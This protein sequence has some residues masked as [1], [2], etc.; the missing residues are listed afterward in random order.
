M[1]DYEHNRSVVAVVDLKTQA[2]VS[3]DLTDIQYQLDD[4]EREEANELAAADSRVKEFLNDRPMNPLTRLYFPPEGRAA[5]PTHR[6][7]IVFLRPN[8]RERRYAVVDLSQ[9][10][11]IQVFGLEQVASE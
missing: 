1:Y 6:H 9:R 3:M 4:E 11:V 10:A 7:A 8:N 5:D 2:V